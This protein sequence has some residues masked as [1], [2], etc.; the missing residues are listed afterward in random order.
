MNKK[1][2]RLFIIIILTL[3]LISAITVLAAANIVPETRLADQSVAIIAS[4][5]VPSECDGLRNSLENF[6]VCTS[7][8][9]SGGAGNSNDLILGTPGNDTIDG[10]NGDDCIVGGAGNDA[11]Y[12]GHGNDIL[13]GG[14]G[15]DTLDGGSRNIDTDTCIDDAGSTTFIDCEVIR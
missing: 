11:L 4:E 12:G 9:C 15:V 14:P 7:T 2:I 8:T 6:I 1:R 3:I 13:I 10:N 5:L